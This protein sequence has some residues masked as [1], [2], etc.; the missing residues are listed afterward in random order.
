MEQ[1]F[2]LINDQL[3]LDERTRSRKLRIRT[4]K[5]VPLSPTAANIEYIKETASLAETITAA[6]SE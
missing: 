4:Y 2:K 3:N 1:A 5:I 6:Y